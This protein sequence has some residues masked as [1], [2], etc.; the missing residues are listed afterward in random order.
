[1]GKKNSLKAIIASFDF[2]EI[3]VFWN[4]YSEKELHGDYYI[5]RN[6]DDEINR[7]FPKSSDFAYAS[8]YGHYD[9]KDK[10]FSIDIDNYGNLLSFNKIDDKY[11]PI[12]LGKL[13]EYL[14]ENGDME[15]PIENGW[16]VEDFIMDYFGNPDES[17]KARRIINNRSESI[18][19]LMEN[20]LDI[21]KEIKAHWND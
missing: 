12:D 19:F 18:D 14:I 2:E 5:Y 11:C 16:L 20:W 9:Y 6:K 1:M 3:V 15:F 8:A 13:A 21:Y 17:E 4:I 10:Y 7:Q